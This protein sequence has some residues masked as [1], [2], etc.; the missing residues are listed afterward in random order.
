LKVAADDKDTI[1][2]WPIKEHF[3]ADSE[4]REWLNSQVISGEFHS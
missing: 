3:P 1:L 2:R 4:F